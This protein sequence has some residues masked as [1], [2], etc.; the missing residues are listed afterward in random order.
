VAGCCEHGNGYKGSVTGES[1]R[2]AELHS[3]SQK[4]LYALQVVT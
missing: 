2:L 4:W 1:F 3:A